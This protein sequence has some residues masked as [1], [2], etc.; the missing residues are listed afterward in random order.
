MVKERKFTSIKVKVRRVIMIAA[1]TALVIG[2]LVG[3]ISLTWVQMIAINSEKNLIR[4]ASETSS[5]AMVKLTDESMQELASSKAETAQSSMRE[6]GMYVDSIA[7]YLERL[8]EHNDPDYTTYLLPHTEYEDNSETLWYS[9]KDQLI[10]SGL[11]QYE[12][13]VVYPVQEMFTKLYQ[14]NK[15]VIGHIYYASANGFMIGYDDT[16]TIVQEYF[17]FTQL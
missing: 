7:I 2:S 8:Y 17:D 11:C 5:E 13:S 14:N 3:I 6:Y 9:Y 1:Q 15:D 16:P 10:D 12:M 4:I